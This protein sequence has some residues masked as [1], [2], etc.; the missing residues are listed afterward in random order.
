MASCPGDMRMQEIREAGA[1]LP[2]GVVFLSEEGKISVKALVKNAPE[3]EALAKELAAAELPPNE[4]ANTANVCLQRPSTLV[5]NDPRDKSISGTTRRQGV[6][7]TV[8]SNMTGSELSVAAPE[9][10]EKEV[11][12]LKVKVA[13]IV[14]QGLDLDERL[15]AMRNLKIA[16]LCANRIT[17]LQTLGLLQHLEL[18]DVSDN[19]VQFIAPTQT[20]LFRQLHVLYLHRNMVRRTNSLKGLENTQ[21]LRILTL[22]GNPVDKDEYYRP[23]VFSAVSSLI[24]L[25]GNPKIPHDYAI[26]ASQALAEKNLD[27]EL[28]ALANGETISGSVHEKIQ[29]A[30]VHRLGVILDMTL[31]QKEMPKLHQKHVRRVQTEQELEKNF[32]ISIL[33]ARNPRDRFNHEFMVDWILRRSVHARDSLLSYPV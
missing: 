23:G 31:E 1:D 14:E 9:E 25:D 5:L 24:I 7:T 15:S 6:G 28:V 3:L 30:T 20:V 26:A 13:Y 22:K 12:A 4:S 32:K 19:L 16:C 10:Q 17:S 21:H 8:T 27:P 29:E 18:L 33:H 11:S 2:H